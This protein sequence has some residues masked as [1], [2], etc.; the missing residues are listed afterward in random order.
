M[1]EFKRENRYLIIKWKDAAAALGTRDLIELQEL[2]S[3][4]AEHRESVGKQRLE[5]VVIESDW[6]IYNLVWA[7]VQRLAEGQDDA[8]WSDDEV[9]LAS[10]DDYRELQSQHDELQS[11][12]VNVKQ[13]RG[14]LLAAL[15]MML[16]T[17]PEPPEANCSCHLCAPCGDCVEYSGERD[18]FDFAKD[19]IAKSKGGAA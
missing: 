18:V 14:E 2:A 3:A 4:V 17:V 19:V 16:E 13:Q 12:L 1:S 6:P 15:E 10:Q 7:E 5:C 11:L 9:Q 8:D